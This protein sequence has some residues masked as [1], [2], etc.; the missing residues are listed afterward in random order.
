ME[1]EPII[2]DPP[3]PK[4]SAPIAKKKTLTPAPKKKLR[5]A[6]SPTKTLKAKDKKATDTIVRPKPARSVTLSAARRL[7]SVSPSKIRKARADSASPILSQ[8]DRIDESDTEEVDLTLDK[9][10]RPARQHLSNIAGSSQDMRLAQEFDPEEDT[11]QNMPKALKLKK[12]EEEL[13]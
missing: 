2:Q 7:L 1:E 13:F 10:G 5:S 8:K 11:A 6:L 12:I 9:D 4:E 3:S